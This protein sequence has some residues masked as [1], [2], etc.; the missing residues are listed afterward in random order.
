MAAALLCRCT[1]TAYQPV[2]PRNTT[3]AATQPPTS[4]Q[5]R[6]VICSFLAEGFSLAILVPLLLQFDPDPQIWLATGT[7]KWQ[8]CDHRDRLGTGDKLVGIADAP[9]LNLHPQGRIATHLPYFFL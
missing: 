4:S 2:D 5:P 6:P 7:Y 3:S 8:S 1:D 9:S